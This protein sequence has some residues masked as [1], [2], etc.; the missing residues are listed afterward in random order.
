MRTDRTSRAVSHGSTGEIRYDNLLAYGLQRG[1]ILV[2][3]PGAHERDVYHKVERSPGTRTPERPGSASAVVQPQGARGARIFATAATS[4]SSK[5]TSATTG[6]GAGFV[7]APLMA[8]TGCVPEAP[9][10]I[11]SSI[12]FTSSADKG[13]FPSLGMK[14]SWFGG[15]VMR[16]KSSLPLASPGLMTAPCLLPR[17]NASYVNQ[18]QIRFVFVLAVAGDAVTG[19]KRLH[20]GAIKSIRPALRRRRNGCFLEPISPARSAVSPGMNSVR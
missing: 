6:V 12:T 19:E 17:I 4:S 15:S 11:H 2:P 9:A 10:V 7:G 16:R 13:R 5:L 18:P 20:A 14:S 1:Q 3:K 8:S